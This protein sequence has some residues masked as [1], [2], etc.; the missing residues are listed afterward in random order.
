MF[1]DI[2]CMDLKYTYY[3]PVKE[4]IGLY[5]VEKKSL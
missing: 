2:D 3:A 5:A 4:I 1:L